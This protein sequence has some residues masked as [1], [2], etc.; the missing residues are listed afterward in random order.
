MKLLHVLSLGLILFAPNSAAAEPSIGVHGW[1]N[2]GDLFSDAVLEIEK[3]MGVDL[4]YSKL[5]RLH[6]SASLEES[7][8]YNDDVDVVGLMAS[9][10]SRFAEA[11][12]VR[13][14]SENGRI[15]YAANQHYNHLKN[16]IYH[17]GKIVGLGIGASLYNF[18]VVDLDSY[19]DLGLGEKD[20]PQDWDAFYDQVLELSETNS[21]FYL[22][23][24]Y[25]GNLGLPVSFISEVL[26]RGGHVIDPL[27]RQSAM[28][29]DSGP[30]YDTLI[31]W[32]RAWQSG[33][34]PVS[35]IEKDQFQFYRKFSS[36]RYLFATLISD[37]FLRVNQA[38][39]LGM[40]RLSPL[41][42][43]K[44]SWGA[45]LLGV[46]SMSTVNDPEQQALV[47]DFLYQYSLGMGANRYAIAEY[48]LDRLGFL[49]VYP[50]F[51]EGPVA[52]NIIRK[53]LA[54]PSDEAVLIDL[55]KTAP[56]PVGEFQVL[57]YEEFSNVLREELIAFLDNP[58]LRPSD[59]INKINRDILEIRIKYG[60]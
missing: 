49:S 40:R 44:Q 55:F 30:A 51:L 47:E 41:P 27:T 57:W 58:E 56:Y 42:R 28:T 7:F 53:K 34:I 50:E 38:E 59:V 39:G 29:A 35:V 8:I 25:D 20:F 23:L 15:V 14:L 12:W 6:Y 22:P 16:A 1:R 9:S 33:A 5:S 32:R 24:W 17:K 18:P 54:R 19:N 4:Q 46:F 10:T 52:R 26:N 60:Y 36:E 31:D 2:V 13:D 3:A 45:A 11:G 21:S 43:F 37:F 48:Y